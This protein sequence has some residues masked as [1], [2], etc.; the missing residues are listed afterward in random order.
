V[1]INL[2]K[3]N[4]LSPECVLL[5]FL[6]HSAGY[7]YELHQRLQD[8]FGNIWH[9]SQSQ[10]YNI[11]KRLETNGIVRST[12]IEQGKHP[13]RQQLQLTPLGV[14][15][16]ED[17]LMQPTR[18]SVHALR[19][20]FITR[21]YFTRLYYPDRL[22]LMINAQVEV[23][24]NALDQLNNQ[25][26]ENADQQ[27]IKKMALELR[28]ELLTSVVHWLDRCLEVSKGERFVDHQGL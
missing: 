18:P 7:G 23:V 28:L 8:E 2:Q 21:L 17:W 4:R 9:A 15:R 1:S 13:A 10:T 24:K 26:E 6:Y 11:L 5:G 22:P 25:R 20:E 12:V 27:T 16:F 19:V 14:Q 3:T